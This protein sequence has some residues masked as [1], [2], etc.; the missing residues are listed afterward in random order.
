MYRVRTRKV[1]C[2][3]TLQYFISSNNNLIDIE[4][5]LINNKQLLKTNLTKN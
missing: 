3:H 1:T 5:E 2:T 4:L